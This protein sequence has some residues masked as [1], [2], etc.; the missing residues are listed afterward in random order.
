MVKTVQKVAHKWENLAYRLLFEPGEVETI[1][2]DTFHQ[3]ERACLEVLR[4]WLLGEHCSP[5]TWLTLLKALRE[6]EFVTLADDLESAL[7]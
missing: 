4:R 5:V 6:C 7:L 2:N 1:R 3:S